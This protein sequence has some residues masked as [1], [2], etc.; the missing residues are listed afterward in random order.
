MTC[1][2]TQLPPPHVT[3]LVSGR[4][5][6]G[7][8][9]W[10]ATF[11]HVHQFELL[12]APVT[13]TITNLTGRTYLGCYTDA[14]N[15]RTLS[16]NIYFDSAMMVGKCLVYCKNQGALTAGV[17][18]GTQCYCGASLPSW[19]VSQG[20]VDPLQYGCSMP[21]GGF[22]LGLMLADLCRE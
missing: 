5:P 4:R 14:L 19:S 17:E 8:L 12:Y 21:C 11:V 22:P 16:T 18:Y 6:D 10:S 7:T 3:N 15:T 13:F 20:S 9:R 1:N 2:G